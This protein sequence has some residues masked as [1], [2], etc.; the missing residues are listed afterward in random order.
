MCDQIYVLSRNMFTMLISFSY[1]LYLLLAKVY[2]MGN[3]TNTFELTKFN[4]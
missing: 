4:I 1:V 3:M 2:T